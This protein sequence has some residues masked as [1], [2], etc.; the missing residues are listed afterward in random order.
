KRHTI[1]LSTHILSEVEVTCSR[2]IIIH[3]GKIEASDT[4]ENLV[5]R[6]RTSGTVRLEVMTGNDDPAQ[7]IEKINGV[8]SIAASQEYGRQRCSI[9]VEANSDPREEIFRLADQPH[10]TIREL[11]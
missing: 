10:W 11:T 2:V 1:L 8:K 6:I 3:R 5:G 4:P 9:R 7:L